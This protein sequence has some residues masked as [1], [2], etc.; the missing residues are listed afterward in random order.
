MN[1]K[2][3]KLAVV[4]IGVMGLKHID[5]I[6]KVGNAELAAVVDFEESATIRKINCS[7]F[8]TIKQMFKSKA[9]DGVIVATPNSSHF[10]DGIEV[11]KNECAVLIEKPITLRSKDTEKLISEAKKKEVQKTSFPLSFN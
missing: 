4:G 5:A 2:K 6:N 3:I 11:I 9:V 7:Y 10:K 8:P 1:N